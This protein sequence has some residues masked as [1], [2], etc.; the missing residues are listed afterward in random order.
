MEIDIEENMDKL[1]LGTRL[2]EKLWKFVVCTGKWSRSHGT[3]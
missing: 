2:G 3:N 1:R